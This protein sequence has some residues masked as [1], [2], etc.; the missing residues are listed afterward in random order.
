MIG[1]D[2]LAWIVCYGMEISSTEINICKK[3]ALTLIYGNGQLIR[4]DVCSTIKF[5]YC[6]EKK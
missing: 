3:T 4:P 6:S 1:I 5:L 2:M